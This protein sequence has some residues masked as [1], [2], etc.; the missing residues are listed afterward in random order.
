MAVEQV[1]VRITMAGAEYHLARGVGNGHRKPYEPLSSKARRH[2]MATGAVLDL[3]L[4][5]D[6]T[7]VG[8]L[9]DDVAQDITLP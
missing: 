9:C 5:G 8:L 3:H 7:F 1:A 2:V 4:E 6:A